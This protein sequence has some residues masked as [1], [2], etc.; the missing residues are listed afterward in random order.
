MAGKNSL[1][2]RKKVHPPGVEIDVE[3]ADRSGYYSRNSL[4]Q[5]FR[6]CPVEQGEVSHELDAGPMVVEGGVT[7]AGLDKTIPPEVELEPLV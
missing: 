2:W 5:R 4:R 3:G 1:K 6:F 7:D